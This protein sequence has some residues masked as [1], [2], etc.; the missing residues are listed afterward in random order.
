MKILHL[1]IDHQVVERTLGV[2]E[3]VFPQCNDI[4]I[5]NQGKELKH[6]E[7]YTNCTQIDN[8]SVKKIGKSFD[9]SI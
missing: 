2:Y 4:I 8:C 1:I 7:K 5:F 9:F 6:I 3:K